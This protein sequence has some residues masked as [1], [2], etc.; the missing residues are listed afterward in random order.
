MVYGSAILATACI[1]LATLTIL[2]GVRLTR[3]LMALIPDES[4]G[5]SAAHRKVRTDQAKQMALR[6]GVFGIGFLAQS[7]ALLVSIFIGADQGEGVTL[8]AL[9]AVYLGCEL[10]NISFL[11]FMY[12]KAIARRLEKD[13]STYGSSGQSTGRGR[14]TNS[15]ASGRS[16]TAQQRSSTRSLRENMVRRSL[17]VRGS[18]MTTASQAERKRDSEFT[19]TTLGL[20]SGKSPRFVRGSEMSHPRQSNLSHPRQSNLSHPRQSNLSHHPYGGT[21]R[22]MEETERKLLDPI[23]DS[24]E[25]S[26]LGR[27]LNGS[28]SPSLRPWSS[29]TPS[30]LGNSRSAVSRVL[31]L[32]QTEAVTVDNVELTD[33]KG[34]NEEEEALVYD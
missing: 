1:V 20:G 14:Y 30:S 9:S 5:D 32:Q 18:E 28:R 21:R 26:S 8:I 7:V 12:Y 11:I 25:E 13:S 3:M 17:G 27:S 33:Y 22:S 10:V 23:P 4:V 29:A 31:G 6:A 24:L 2:Y 15:K 19:S 34:S 16:S